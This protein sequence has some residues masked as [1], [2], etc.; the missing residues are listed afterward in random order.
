MAGGKRAIRPLAAI[1]IAGALAVI[2][3]AAHGYA[4]AVSDPVVKSFYFVDPHWPRETQHFALSLQRTS[5][6]MVPR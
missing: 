4:E 1:A 5:T 2:G 3:I 6:S